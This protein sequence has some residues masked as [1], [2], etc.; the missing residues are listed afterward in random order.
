MSDASA[1][2]KFWQ[3]PELVDTLLTFLDGDS[4]LC[5]AI[6]H[7]LTKKVSQKSTVWTKVVKRTCPD[8]ISPWVGTLFV[9]P[10]DEKTLLRANKKKMAPCWSF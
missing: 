3:T 5:L 4:I 10:P 8:V 2:A 1:V 6:C 7:D 9:F